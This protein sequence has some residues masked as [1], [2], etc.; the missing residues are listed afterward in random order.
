[1][2]RTSRKSKTSKVPAEKVTKEQNKTESKIDP[3]NKENIGQSHDSSKISISKEDK[4]RKQS[5][6]KPDDEKDSYDDEDFDD[7]AVVIGETEENE[8]EVQI[9][10]HPDDTRSAIKIERET[11]VSSQTPTQKITAESLRLT[12]ESK[13]DKHV[14]E[15]ED[16]VEL[17]TSGEIIDRQ[18]RRVY[19]DDHDGSPLVELASGKKVDSE[20]QTRSSRESSLQGRFNEVK[21]RWN[22][23]MER[24]GLREAAKDLKKNFFSPEKRAQLRSSRQGNF[25]Q[26]SSAGKLEDQADMTNLSPG[27]TLASSPLR[28][29]EA[30]LTT[31]A[32][33]ECVSEFDYSM[34]DV[35]LSQCDYEDMMKNFNQRR[36]AWNTYIKDEKETLSQKREIFSKIQGERDYLRKN[37]QDEEDSEGSSY[38]GPGSYDL[39]FRALEGSKRAGAFGKGMRFKATSKTIQSGQESS[40]TDTT[41]NYDIVKRKPKGFVI[42]KEGEKTSVLKMKQKEDDLV[43]KARETWEMTV[44]YRFKDVVHENISSGVVAYDKQSTEPVKRA[45]TKLGPG[46]YSAEPIKKHVPTPKIMQPTETIDLTYRRRLP[47]V[48][49][50]DLNDDLEHTHFPEFSFPKETSEKKEHRDRR[51][52][53]DVKDDVIRKKTYEAHIAPLIDVPRKE[54]LEKGK[55]GPGTYTVQYDRVEPRP[56]K[57]VI[58]MDQVKTDSRKDRDYEEGILDLN[59]DDHVLRPDKP[60]FKYHEPVE[61]DGPSNLPEY[62]PEHWRFYEGNLEAIKG[63]QP[64]A[65]LAHKMDYVE[66]QEYEHDMKV[67]SRIML[68]DVRQ[69]ESGD[70]DPKRVDLERIKGFDFS[71]ALP[72]EET[73]PLSAE[74]KKEGDLL[75]LNPSDDSQRPRLAHGFDM[76]KQAGRE[77]YKTET[78]EGDCLKIEPKKVEKRVKGVMSFNQQIGRSDNEDPAADDVIYSDPPIIDVKDPSDR[79]VSGPDFSKMK[80]RTDDD[81]DDGRSFERPEVILEVRETAVRRKMPVYVDMGKTTGREEVE[82]SD[83]EIRART[84]DIFEKDRACKAIEKSTPSVN[85]GKSSSRKYVQTR[86][87]KE[88]LSRIQEVGGEEDI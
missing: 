54:D 62:K 65:F 67:L 20:N 28:G 15:Q 74:E 72:R 49:Q 11:T 75:V 6:Q 24:S 73:D 31:C 4:D 35:D 70:Y 85:I 59:P 26:I 60:T 57:G 88:P 79:R 64:E 25:K 38:L 86:A 2:G 39:N 9:V 10:T 76:G 17:A 71:K 50:Y 45:N 56:D 18:T 63:H 23:E 61:L 14:D 19:F 51:K 33:S 47:G 68:K 7:D 22:D 66:F 5:T 16:I 78:H 21:E 44:D 8:S 40:T 80:G 29:L 34:D 12:T 43:Q 13:S 52:A 77:E 81:D 58:K 83:F 84:E 30:D 53:L 69:P 55:R 82:K 42:S 41:P 46:H 36:S 27:S 37:K 1:V 87:V 32:G 48:G 3:K